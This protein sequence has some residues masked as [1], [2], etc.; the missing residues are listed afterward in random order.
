VTG[1]QLQGNQTPTF[2]E[3]MTGPIT[4][5]LVIETPLAHS[6]TP[7]GASEDVMGK[8]VFVASYVF[9]PSPGCWELAAQ[10]GD[11]HVK[12]VVAVK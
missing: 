3:G 8:F 7:G 1:R 9:Y 4:S 12:V 6:M 2:S 5:S 11:R 10:L